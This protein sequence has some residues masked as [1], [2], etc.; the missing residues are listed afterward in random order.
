[1]F[2]ESLQGLSLKLSI[3]LLPGLVSVLG[4]SLENLSGWVVTR[5]GIS[6]S[7]AG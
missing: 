4:K 2:V 6:L 7:F 3:I 5:L 1:M